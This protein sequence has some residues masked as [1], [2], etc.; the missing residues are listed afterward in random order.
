MIP[1]FSVVTPN[2]HLSGTTI[3]KIA[4]ATNRWK[5]NSTSNTLQVCL[6]VL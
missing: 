5:L 3:N 4:C 2:M 6:Q 1:R